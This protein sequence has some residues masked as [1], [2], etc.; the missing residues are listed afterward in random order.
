[1][2][3]TSGKGRIR[4]Y[5]TVTLGTF[6]LSLGVALFIFPFGLVTGGVSGL[7]VII[8]RVMPF[9][10]ITIDLVVAVLS[11][12]FFTLG[13]IFLG[14]EF[15]Y[16]TL[17][18]SLLYPIFIAVLLPVT[19]QD[20][21]GGFFS[22]SAGALGE[23]GIII[24]SVFGGVLV[25]VGCAMTFIAGGST[26]GTDILAFLLCKLVRRMK[27][28]RAIFIIDALIIILGA[29][30]T[31]DLGVSLL[32]VGVAIITATVIDRVFLGVDGGLTAQIITS[33]ASG[34]TAEIIARMDRTATVLDC[35]G[36]Y[37]NEEKKLVLV[38]LAMRE[39]ATLIG[40]VRECDRQ[41]FVTV[42]RAH[43]IRGEGW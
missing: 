26:G 11:A 29:A 5:I 7:A 13:A 16:K 18:S 8:D 42:M 41:A 19:G 39:Y 3:I 23:S 6:I 33:R 43:E 40:I 32:G 15:A 17:L 10:F 27:T 38:S 35:R 20:F 4:G 24:A 36:A 34:I 2:K 37:S 9:E 12:L 21:L 30:V 1:M 25:G 14:R 28:S 31:R 22:L